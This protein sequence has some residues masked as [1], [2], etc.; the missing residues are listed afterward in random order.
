MLAANFAHALNR[1]RLV[2]VRPSTLEKVQLVQALVK[3][4]HL[5][6]WTH[7]RGPEVP[8]DLLVPPRSFRSLLSTLQMNSIPATVKI[9]DVQA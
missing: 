4:H 1:H 7:A 2:S 5:Q 3:T 6:E 8:V 9:D